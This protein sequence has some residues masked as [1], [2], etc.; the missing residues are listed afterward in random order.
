MEITDIKKIKSG[1][2]IIIED[3][4]YQVSEEILLTMQLY[5]GKVLT[6]DQ[7][8]E[9]LKKEEQYQLF[10]KAL[11]FILYKERSESEVKKYLYQKT[12]NYPFIIE[13]VE[14]LKQHKY[15]NDEQYVAHFI[16][17]Y[18]SRGKGKAYIRQKLN[19]KGL[20]KSLVEEQLSQVKESIFVDQMRVIVQK[21]LPRLYQYPITKQ[22]QVLMQKLTRSGYSSGSAFQVLSEFEFVSDHR[23][24]LEKEFTKLKR[25]YQ[26]KLTKEVKQKMIQSLMMK[27]FDFQEISQL[28]K[29]DEN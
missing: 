16:E 20:N 15:I 25:K 21:E 24:L 3:S 17:S 10:S 19:E 28:M 5:V 29:L 12:Q 27:G 23:A 26:N 11:N 8:A 18:V 7:L 1:Y 4:K 14:K 22:K 13:L 6:E 2:T 9:L